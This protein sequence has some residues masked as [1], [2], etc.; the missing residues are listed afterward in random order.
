MVRTLTVA[1]AAGLAASTAHAQTPGVGSISDYYGPA[2][3]PPGSLGYRSWARSDPTCAITRT[4]YPPPPAAMAYAPLP[5]AAPPAVEVP[6][7]PPLGWVFGGYTN[8][9]DQSCGTLFVTVPA[10]GLNVRTIPNGPAV[11]SLV[12]GT[13]LVVVQ[14]QG[15]WT[16]VA[17]GCNLAP[18]GLW[19]W[20]AG[21]PLSGCL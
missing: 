12:N 8:C 15:D 7:P 10:D 3:A 11:L 6:P 9:G 16:L 13:P 21:V 1:L 4:C 14:R 2:T 17:P 5:P 19:S 20:T 18:T